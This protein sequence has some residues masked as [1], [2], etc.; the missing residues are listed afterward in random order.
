MSEPYTAAQKDFIKAHGAYMTTKELH[1]T[2]NITFGCNHSI[3]SVR[4]TT[5]KLGIKKSESVRRK[6]AKKEKYN[7]GD[8]VLFHGYE[9]IKV[10]N[11]DGFWN[12]WKPKANVIWESHFW[13]IPDGN[14]VVFLNGN[15]RD[16]R[17]ENLAC[18]SKRIAAKMANGHGKSL[19]SESP[20][21]T[22]TA[23][24]ACELEL[25]I[26]CIDEE[27]DARTTERGLT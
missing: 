20:D 16:I 10:S 21:I 6:N 22:K 14:Q 3:G 23:I 13:K 11:D 17:I 12:A 7:I 9:I 27:P 5:K 2:L 19:W 24:L 15:K 26:K 25:T 4:T 1:Q 18:I 8:T